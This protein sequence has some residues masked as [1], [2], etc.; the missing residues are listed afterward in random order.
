MQPSSFFDCDKENEYFHQYRVAYLIV[1]SLKEVFIRLRHV[2]CF[3]AEN[4]TTGLQMLT[5]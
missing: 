5:N 1:Y 2:F 4:N 3:I